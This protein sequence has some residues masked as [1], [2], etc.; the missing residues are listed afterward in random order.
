MSK[1]A[2]STKK[3]EIQA[4]GSFVLCELKDQNSNFKIVSNNGKPSGDLIVVSVGENVKCCKAGDKIL[5]GIENMPQVELPS[6]NKYI[7]LSESQVVGV[8]NV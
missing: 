6:G 2:E 4:V 5:P 8:F 7:L 3:P 1:T